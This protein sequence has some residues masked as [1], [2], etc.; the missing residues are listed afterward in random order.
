MSSLYDCVSL[1][2]LN[3]PVYIDTKGP[4][5]VQSQF[6]EKGNYTS[7]RQA[8]YPRKGESHPDMGEGLLSCIFTARQSGP[9]HTAR[10]PGEPLILDSL[11]SP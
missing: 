11:S 9:G 10:T 7:E 8:C 6:T 5:V 3:P 1:Y 4:R 2:G